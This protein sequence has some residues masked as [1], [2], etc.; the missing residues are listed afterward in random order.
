MGVWGPC[1]G[2]LCLRA[3]F[4]TLFFKLPLLPCLPLLF[5][6]CAKM[7]SAPCAWHQSGQSPWIQEI[8]ERR[9]KGPL[10]LQVLQSD[11]PSCTVA[12]TLS[13][14]GFRGWR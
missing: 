5:Y 14:P 3:W 1:E 6:L 8:P 10:V 13:W 4:C 12:R 2:I 11:R 9:P 7:T